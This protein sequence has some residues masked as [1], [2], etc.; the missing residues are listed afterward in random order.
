MLGELYKPKGKALETAKAVLECENVY[1]VNV[2]WGCTVGC[3]YPCY[4]WFRT[5]GKMTFP[6]K[7]PVELV[8]KQLE[9]GLEP[10][11]VFISFGCE[12]LLKENMM[13][14]L[15]LT[16]LLRRHNIKVAILSKKNILFDCFYQFYQ[17]G[18][19]GVLASF[20]TDQSVKH[21]MT[22]VSLSHIFDFQYEAGALSSVQRVEK[23]QKAS[24][25]GCYTWGSIEPYPCPEIFK[26]DIKELLERLSFVNFMIFGRW[27]YDDRADTPEAKQ[28]YVDAAAEFVDFCKAHGIRY[29]VKSDVFGG[30]YYGGKEKG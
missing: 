1:A 21:G 8:K 2:A 22:I 16:A 19:A 24:N 30:D 25:L 27:N 28:F 15:T 4:N 14:T 17:P 12:P 5:K 13:H 3:K 18:F 9:D 29:H 23:L 11:G 10:E 26:Q 6:E 20:V 7:P